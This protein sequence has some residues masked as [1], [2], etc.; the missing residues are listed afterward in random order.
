MVPLIDQDTG[1][2]AGILW[3]RGFPHGM[4]LRQARCGSGKKSKR[5]GAAA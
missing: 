3:T 2:P 1:D 4:D 5:R